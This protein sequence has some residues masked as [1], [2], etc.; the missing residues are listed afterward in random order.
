MSAQHLRSKVDAMQILII[1]RC[2]PYPLHLGDRLIVYH[3]ARELSAR[4][5]QIDLVAFYDR[6]EDGADEA[7][8]AYATALKLARQEPE[9]RFLQSRLDALER[10]AGSA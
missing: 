6:D 8:A 9:R 5:H 1:S 3:L 10:P 7:Q 4:G 2:P